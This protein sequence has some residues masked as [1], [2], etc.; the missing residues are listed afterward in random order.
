MLSLTAGQIAMTLA[1]VTQ[2][3]VL[4]KVDLDGQQYNVYIEA[5]SKTFKTH[6]CIYVLLYEICVISMTVIIE[7]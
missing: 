3:P 4:T 1:P 7:L 5:D 6:S 2:R